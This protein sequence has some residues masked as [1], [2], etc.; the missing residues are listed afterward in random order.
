[1]KMKD[2]LR[3][4]LAVAVGVGSAFVA[5]GSDDEYYFVIG[6]S[7]IVYSIILAILER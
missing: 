4:I 3:Y 1:M 6:I 7:I 5:R 2:K